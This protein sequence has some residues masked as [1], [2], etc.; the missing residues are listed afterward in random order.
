[1]RIDQC[2]IDT[3]AGAYIDAQFPNTIGQELMVSK[4]AKLDPVDSAINCNSRLDVTKLALPVEINVF[5]TRC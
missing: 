5:A 2:V 4:I 1:M 3:V